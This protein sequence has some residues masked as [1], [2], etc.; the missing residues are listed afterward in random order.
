M[1]KLIYKITDTDI[2]ENGREAS[3]IEFTIPDDMNI[4]EYKVI[5]VRMASALGYSDTSISKGFGDLIY[6]DDE[7]PP[8]FFENIMKEIQERSTES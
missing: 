8:D 1:A 4:H 5:C 3:E 7:L 6:G 2:L